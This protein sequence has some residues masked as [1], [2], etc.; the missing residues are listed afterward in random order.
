MLGAYYV[1]LERLGKASVV[2]YQVGT[3]LWGAVSFGHGRLGKRSDA[4]RQ[5]RDG[6]EGTYSVDY[7]RLGKVSAVSRQDWFARL[8][9]SPSFTEGC[10][11]RRS[12]AAKFGPLWSTLSPPATKVSPRSLRFVGRILRRPWKVREGRP[13]CAFL[14]CPPSD[15]R[16]KAGTP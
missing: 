14:R 2:G 1:D 9:R 6:L 15:L 3:L 4:C 16:S 10:G 7:G 12:P 13:R 8:E 5:A 11:R